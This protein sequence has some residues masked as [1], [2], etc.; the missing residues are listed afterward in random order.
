MTEKLIKKINLIMERLK[1]IDD[2]ENYAKME[3]LLKEL[4]SKKS[5]SKKSKKSKNSKKSKSKSKSKS[6]KSKKSKSKSK[7]KKSK[8]YSK[9]CSEKGKKIDITFNTDQINN[10]GGKKNIVTMNNG[11]Y[12]YYVDISNKSINVYAMT[13]ISNKTKKNYDIHFNKHVLCTNYRDVFIGD[14]KKNKLGYGN[15]V[16]INTKNN[17]Y[18]FICEKIVK[19]T[20]K[21]K[22]L[23]YYSPIANGSVPHPYGIDN[24]GNNYLI[25]DDDKKIIPVLKGKY[26]DIWNDYYDNTEN[27][28]DIADMIKI[29]VINEIKS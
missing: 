18:I 8:N 14:D 25:Y 20:T 28:V 15:S 24:K 23:K 1:T 13:G 12:F 26:K 2:K 19:F 17:E 9:K 3:L 6:K 27:D 5:K 4:K 21:N 16:L 7:S 10:R 22:I 11:E 29:K